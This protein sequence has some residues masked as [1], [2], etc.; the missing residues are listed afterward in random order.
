MP[1]KTPSKEA[2]KRRMATE[3]G[4]AVKLEKPDGKIRIE[5]RPSREQQEK[6]KNSVE[7]FE[8]SIRGKLGRSLGEIQG[9]ANAL[10]AG[11][12]RDFLAHVRN[13]KGE[14][15][16]DKIRKTPLRVK[17]KGTP[18]SGVAIERGARLRGDENPGNKW[19]RGF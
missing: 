11:K 8:K 19:V 2:I 6:K 18:V 15:M 17:P 16:A 13:L 1:S 3:I 14:S 9:P 7:R 12:P 10:L 4:K 5:Y